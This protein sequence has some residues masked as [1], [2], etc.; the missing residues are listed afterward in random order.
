[1]YSAG[2]RP[3]RRVRAHDKPSQPPPRHGRSRSGSEQHKPGEPARQSGIYEVIH[4]NNHRQTHE[5]VMLAGDLFPTCDTCNGQVR[6]H[7]IRT[8]PYIFQDEDF[9]DQE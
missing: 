9:E 7:L 8:A 1:V 5:V 2:E 4:A 6:F 3:L